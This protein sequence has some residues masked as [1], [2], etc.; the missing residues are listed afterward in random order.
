MSKRSEVLFDH[1]A[2]YLRFIYKAQLFWF[3]L[4]MSYDHGCHLTNRFRLD[5]EEYEVLLIVAGL[6]S[7]TR[8]GWLANQGHGQLVVTLPHPLV[9]G[10]RRHNDGDG[11][12][13]N[14]KGLQGLR[15]HDNGNG[16]HDDGWYDNDKGQRGDRWHDNGDRRHDD[17]KGQQGDRRHDVGNERHD[18][19]WH[20]NGKRQR[21]DRRHNNSDGRH[22]GG[23]GQ[24]GVRRH[25][26]SNRRHDSGQH[27]DG[28]GQQ[29]NRWHDNGDGRRAA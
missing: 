1:I 17:G 4:N 6:A 23:K 19:E 20:G 27:D 14:G 25:G 9:L 11:Q 13:D 7:Y 21:G 29:G 26:N 2:D 10:D 22:E 3:T 8:F 5:P 18:N 28:K 15:R 24:Q 16:W 12:H